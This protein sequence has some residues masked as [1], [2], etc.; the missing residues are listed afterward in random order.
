MVAS[1]PTD[2]DLQPAE[3]STVFVHHVPPAR[4]NQFV[5][6]QK[7]VSSAAKRLPGYVMTEVYRP[8]RVQSD[9]WVVVMKFRNQESLDRWLDSEERADC[10]TRIPV[11]INSSVDKMPAG[12]GV[13]FAGLERAESA[14]NG[15]PVDEIPGWKMFMAVLLALYPAVMLLTLFVSP[16]LSSA[17]MAFTML[18]GNALS[19]GLLQWVLMPSLMIAMRRWL[20][21]PFATSP[22]LNLGARWA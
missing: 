20:T 2:I 16:W 11:Q 22:L 9:Q 7:E 5:Q 1:F 21:T 3:A 18:I 13:W 19:V 8:G 12:F 17:G 10:L 14:S 15:A 6:W 4:T